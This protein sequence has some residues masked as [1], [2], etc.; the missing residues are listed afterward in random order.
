VQNC[1]RSLAGVEKQS[2]MYG[3]ASIQRLLLSRMLCNDGMRDVAEYAP[4]QRSAS[5]SPSATGCVTAR[6]SHGAMLSSSVI[7]V[8]MSDRLPSVTIG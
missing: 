3:S 6:V 5:L 7:H 2:I 4:K 1:A 8:L